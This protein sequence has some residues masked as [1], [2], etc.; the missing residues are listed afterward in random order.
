MRS[1]NVGSDTLTQSARS[2]SDRLR[3]L[4]RA[5]ARLVARNA[6]ILGAVFVLGVGSKLIGAIREIY[7]SSRFGVGPITDTFFAV[8]QFPASISNYLFGAF[9]LAFVPHYIAAKR[10]GL[11]RRLTAKVATFLF[12]FVCALTVATSAGHGALV[13]LLTGLKQYRDLA[14]GFSLII[15][16]SFLPIAANGLAFAV[17]HAE[18]KHNQAMMLSALPPAAMMA[19][20]LCWL[21]VPSRFFS[22][23][24]PWS[25]VIGSSLGGVWSVWTLARRTPRPV[26]VSL[27]ADPPSGF[28]RQLAASSI[29]NLAFNINL[30]L[31]VHFAALSGPGGVAV[32]TYSQRISMLA[33]S[34]A[35]IPLAQVAQTRLSRAGSELIPAVFGR[36]IVIFALAFALVAVATYSFRTPLVRLIYQRGAF[37]SGDTAAVSAA[38]APY[39]AYFLVLALNTVFARFFF[40]ISRGQIYTAVLLGGYIL[41]NS[42]KAYWGVT[43]GVPGIAL[44]GTVGEGAAL[45]VLMMIFVMF[46]GRKA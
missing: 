14:T 28:A 11:E 22:L 15:A 4:P 29:E 24:L 10:C 27:R 26:P 32:N 46:R 44:S 9:T 36:M 16:L 37:H 20:L 19:S 31:T 7:I 8:Q 39:S 42:L 3:A 13:P 45:V 23:A 40:S 6:A 25:F 35:V 12:A 43:N 2:L 21:L 38:L 18:G 30:I 1:V 34:G 5:F 41:G 33:L 17:L